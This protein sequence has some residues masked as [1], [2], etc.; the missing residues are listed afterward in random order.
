M[1]SYRRV[2]SR[3]KDLKASMLHVHDERND[4]RVRNV[5]IT[6]VKAFCVATRIKI[7]NINGFR[8]TRSD[9]LASSIFQLNI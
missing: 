4:T 9:V 5:R 8:L 3:Q 6:S 2:I 1:T 7:R